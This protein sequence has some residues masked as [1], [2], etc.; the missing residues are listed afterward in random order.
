VSVIYETA[1]KYLHDLPEEKLY[2]AVDY[3][4][5]LAAQNYPLDDFDYE[6]AKR[7]DN[8]TSTETTPFG[9]AYRQL[10]SNF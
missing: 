9:D 1:V 7:A 8:D 4:R 2:S 6:L 3:L 10:G 5:F